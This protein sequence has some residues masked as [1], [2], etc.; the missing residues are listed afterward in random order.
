MKTKL[1]PTLLWLCP[2]KVND[3]IRIGRNR[4]GGY[5]VPKSVVDY[6]DGVLSLGLG[7]DWS[8][9]ESWHSLK[10]NDPIHMYDGAPEGRWNIDLHNQCTSFFVDNRVY[11]KEH[12]YSENNDSLHR[13]SFETALDRMSGNKIMLKMD[14]EGAEVPIMPNIINARDRLIGITL[15]LHDINRQREQFQTI[16]N[17]LKHYYKIVHFHGN[18]FSSLGKEG[19]TDCIELTFIRNDLVPSNELRYQVWQQDLDFSN[20]HDGYDI[21]YYFEDTL[22]LNHMA[23]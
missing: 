19:L 21:E 16:V 20:T 11:Y 2:V 9:D 23:P 4:D 14:I 10:P 3:L 22:D 12:V 13:I 6:A 17:D 15:E 5:I 18:N 7:D 1:P 8:F